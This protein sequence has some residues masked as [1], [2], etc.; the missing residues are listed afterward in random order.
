MINSN[1]S[2]YCRLTPFRNT[3]L[4]FTHLS[5]FKPIFFCS[6]QFC[7]SGSVCFWASRVRICPYFV[8]IR[9]LP[10]TSKKS[11]TNLDF[12]FLWLLFDFSSLLTTDG[13]SKK[14]L[15]NKLIWNFLLSA[16]DEKSRGSGSV[17]QWYGSAD[18]DPNQTVTDPQHCPFKGIMSP[19][20]YFEFPSHRQLK[21]VK[22]TNAHSK[23]TVLFPILGPKKKIFTSWHCPFK[24]VWLTW[25]PL[26]RDRR[27]CRP[28][29]DS[30]SW[31]PPRAGSGQAASLHFRTPGQSEI[32]TSGIEQC[33][34]SSLPDSR[35][36]WN[37]HFRYWTVLSV[38]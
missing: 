30:S 4:L 25:S 13:I 11:K 24:H 15:K 23:S 35:T 31:S 28:G 38:Q 37:T 14:T 34:E 20:E 33:C 17:S 19:V 26:R 22:T 6:L 3:S 27:P 10:S 21:I 1:E 5:T 36:I 12:Y 8:R 29:R 2:V 9:I 32:H 7:G 18:P 16:T